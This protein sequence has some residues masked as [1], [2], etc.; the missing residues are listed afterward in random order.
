MDNL[1]ADVRL[2]LRTWIK[3]PGFFALAALSLAAAIGVIATVVSLANGTI[4]RAVPIRDS[5]AVVAIQ[6]LDRGKLRAEQSYPNYLDYRSQT[7]LFT[8]VGAHYPLLA[9][10]VSIGRDPQRAIGQLVN[11]DYFTTLGVQPAAGTFPADGSGADDGGVV[12][13]NEFWI[14][15][16]NRSPDAIG[17]AIVVNGVPLTI[18]GVAPPEFSGIAFG[19]KPLLWA[20]LSRHASILHTQDRS[21]ARKQDWIEVVG[22]LRPGVSRQEAEARL[23][24][25]AT[26]RDAPSDG[27]DRKITVI[28]A[29]VS[30]LNPAF[31]AGITNVI[32]VLTV[33]C[34][35]LML[36]A[37][38]NVAAMFV[39]RARW[40]EREFAIRFSLGATRGRLLRQ[41]AV[42][43]VLFATIVAALA[44][45]FTYLA[46]RAL[47]TV[48]LPLPFPVE[49]PARLDWKVATFC[50]IG[51]ALTGICVAVV[52]AF[53]TARTGFVR[54]LNNPADTLRRRPTF[55]R[56]QSSLLA[57]QI[58]LS[59]V[60]VGAFLTIAHGLTKAY[61]VPLGFRTDNLLLMN[62]DPSGQGY[63]PDTFRAMV[64]RFDEELSSL[65]GVAAV[66]LTDSPPLSFFGNGAF[67][68]HEGDPNT[69]DYEV[70]VERYRVTPNYF[71]AM[72]V[73][74]KQGTLPRRGT[75]RASDVVVNTALAARMFP[76]QDAIGQRFID[77]DATRTVIAVVGDTITRTVDGRYAPAMYMSL[78]ET[79][80]GEQQP[81][82]IALLIRTTSEPTAMT[83]AVRSRLAQIDPTL[84]VFNLRTMDAQLA[85]VL[86]VP[87][88][89]SWILGVFGV[90]AVLA[91][92]AGIYGLTNYIV[93]SR[94]RELG[95]RMALGAAPMH[96]ASVVAR[97]ALWCAL[98]GSV[99]GLVGTF[100]VGQVLRAMIP[101]ASADPSL[102]A[103][104]LLVVVGATYAASFGPARRAIRIDPVSI[105]RSE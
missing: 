31:R 48:H 10:N 100:A 54:P 60:L 35:I 67:I 41:I 103:L 6:A 13:S 1:I 14:A 50:G 15:Q 37:C 71:K 23:N 62:I 85:T 19:V 105:I 66:A 29:P 36:I 21:A 102:L 75:A 49:L 92:L 63:P 91:M 82:G 61:D 77:G 59:T 27:S 45:G 51:A 64:Q 99:L 47:V 44:I 70:R 87:R 4:F 78:E 90:T 34:T 104:T 73:P 32:V 43:G 16:F 33:L 58:A 86:F 98:V 81:A 2:T 26:Y 46:T 11:A 7:D 101:N 69:R 88:I 39:A 95:I 25:Q 9:V 8:N 68:R 40:R 20:P 30:T 17:H 79:Y 53:A 76:G 72:E 83:G 57:L 84:P 42:E 65:P 3:A 12:I 55:L 24:A 52:A 93:N 5:G 80:T 74:L 97:R 94:L 38:T 56:F 89:G 18:I 96:V 22:R 28:L